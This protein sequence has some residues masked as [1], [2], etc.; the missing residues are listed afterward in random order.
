MIRAEGL[1][2]GYPGGRRVLRDCGL[3]VRPGEVLAVL[4]PNGSGKSTLLK[5][6]AG[7]LEPAEG[8]VW[9]EGRPAASMGRIE[10]AKS[11][12][13]VPQNPRLPEEWS[14]ADVLALGD[15][16][17]REE[18]P[19]PRPLGARLSEAREALDLGGVWGRAADTLSGGE[20]QRVALGRALVQDAGNLLLDEPFSHLDLRHQLALHGLLRSLARLGRSILLATHDL[21]LSQLFSH[22]VVLLGGSGEITAFPARPEEQARVLEVAFGVDFLPL[23]VQGVRCWF[24]TVESANKE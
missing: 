11:V 2:F 21:N 13:Y 8:R 7:L 15:Y 18:P 16:P 10:R 14:V 22:R 9:I 23:E 5:L 24:P 4:G 3:E 1:S 6:A 19:A 20:A 17:H 12:A